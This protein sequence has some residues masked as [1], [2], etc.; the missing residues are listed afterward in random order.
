M[1]TRCGAETEGKVIQRLPHLEIHPMYSR[2]DVIVD[3][4]KCLLIE[5]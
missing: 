4:G 5:A 3:V 1:E 2:P